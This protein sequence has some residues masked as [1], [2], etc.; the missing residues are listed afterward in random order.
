MP[1]RIWGSA[2]LVVVLSIGFGA[3]TIAA[4]AHP[5]RG[6][7][8]D[9]LV[10]DTSLASLAG[11]TVSILGSGVRVVTGTNGRFQVLALPPG[12]YVLVV[13]RLG[14]TPLSSTVQVADRDTMHLSFS[15]EP[16]AAS[17]DTVEV[18]A[19]GPSMRLSEFDEHR[20]HGGGQFMTGAEIERRNS[21]MTFDLLRSFTAVTLR[22]G[23]LANLR[24]G[25]ASTCPFQYFLDGVSIPTPKEPELPSPKELG[26]IEVYATSA[27]IPI[28]YRTVS[29]GGFCGVILLWTRDGVPDDPPAARPAKQP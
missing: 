23:I 12:S 21:V 20:K 6:G 7:V 29:G 22:G 14:Y 3:G 24:A 13:H 15:L 18:A 27:Q 17:L 16:V 1:S 8:I 11:A 2:A 19:R 28:R 25:A 5:S 9:G 10:T 26:G 4:Q